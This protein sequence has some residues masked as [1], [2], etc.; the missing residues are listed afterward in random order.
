MSRVALVVSALAALTAAAEPG[1][2]LTQASL[3]IDAQFAF[4]GTEL[5]PLGP[6]LSLEATWALSPRWSLGGELD[7][8]RHSGDSTLQ[9]FDC[10][11]FESADSLRTGPVLR[12][13][14]WSNEQVALFAQVSP[15]LALQLSRLS[16]GFAGGS[17]TTSAFSPEL[18]LRAGAL[19]R[20]TRWLRL[21]ASVEVYGGHDRAG[22]TGAIVAALIF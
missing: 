5:Q 3:G 17:E 12:W 7:W 11:R 19:I 22:A 4:T 20:V 13:R 2:V 14:F 1:E 9:C 8:S 16:G 15:Q 21:G 6:V 18:S 10:Q